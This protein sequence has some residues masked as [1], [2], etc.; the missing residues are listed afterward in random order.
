MSV[1]DDKL[2]IDWTNGTKQALLLLE[3]YEVTRYSGLQ[4]EKIGK[5]GKNHETDFGGKSLLTLHR[6]V[7]ASK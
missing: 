5:N 2:Y 3:D 1:G 4:K 7:F 6:L